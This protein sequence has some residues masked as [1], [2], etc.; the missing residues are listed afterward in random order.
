MKL[1]KLKFLLL[2]VDHWPSDG[3]KKRYE[4]SIYPS[5]LGLHPSFCSLNHVILAYMETQICWN[6]HSIICIPVKYRLKQNFFSGW[7][8]VKELRNT[9]SAEVGSD[10]LGWEFWT[11]FSQMKFISMQ[12]SWES[13]KPYTCTYAVMLYLILSFCSPSFSCPVSFLVVAVPKH[14]F[15]RK[16]TFIAC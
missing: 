7:Q 5:F 11:W 8:W 9:W 15:G 12:R 6:T 14:H 16:A 2:V 1:P 3:P 10:I 4:C 13:V